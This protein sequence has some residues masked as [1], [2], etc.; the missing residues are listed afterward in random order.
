[1]REREF[2]KKEG[3]EKERERE[4]EILSWGGKQEIKNEQENLKDNVT[5]KACLALF[6]SLFANKE[7]NK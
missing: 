1:M 5:G 4:R 3:G 2:R 6:I 7:T